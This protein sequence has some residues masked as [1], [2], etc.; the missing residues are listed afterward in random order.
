VT[1]C[2]TN[3]IRD[4]LLRNVKK[5]ALMTTGRG[6]TDL[7]AEEQPA[8]V[9]HCPHCNGVLNMIRT[10]RLDVVGSRTTRFGA[11][12]LYACPNC[13][14]LLGITHRKGFWMG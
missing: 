3:L 1:S 13:N 5:E 6:S 14:K 10:R 4:E 9:P 12:Y 7:I 2:P 11:R 8:L